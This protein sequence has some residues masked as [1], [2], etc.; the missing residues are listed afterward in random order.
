MILGLQI[1]AL[2]FALIMLYFAYLHYKRGEI[3]GIEF[4]FWFLAWCG[5]IF[6]VL[7]PQIFT[8][9]ARAIAVS[10]AFD[11][12]VIG[13][14]ILIIPLVYLAYVRTRRLEKKLEDYVR[15]EALRLLK[16]KK[17]G[18]S[19]RKSRFSKKSGK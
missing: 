17:T 12:A 14:F 16:T 1:I 3:N 7:F 18:V 2:T 9:F 8:I 19:N 4:A 11:L 5:A 10:R 15:E 6:I 13:G